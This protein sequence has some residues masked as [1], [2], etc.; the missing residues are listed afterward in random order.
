MDLQ[1][2]LWPVQRVPAV[3]ASITTIA[4][5]TP[6]AVAATAATVSFGAWAVASTAIAGPAANPPVAT[7]TNFATVTTDTIAVVI[8]RR[9]LR[10]LGRLL[11]HTVLH[12]LTVAGAARA[13]TDLR[14]P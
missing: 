10:S 1:K 7:A 14:L 5:I 9:R 12:L 8:G 6:S 3:P 4:T 13:R 11:Q 2:D